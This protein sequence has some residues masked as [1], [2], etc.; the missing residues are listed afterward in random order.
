AHEIKNPLG[1]LRGAA[2]L[3]ESELDSAELQEYTHIIIQEAD[4]LQELV[5]RMLGPNRRPS[6]EPVNIHHVLER[7]RTLVLAETAERMTIIRD[8]DPSIPELIGDHDQLIQAMLNVVRNAA[9]ALGESGTVTLRTRIQRQL[10]IG[11][12]RYRLAAK[13]DIID[14]GPGIPPEIADTLFLPMVTAGTGGMGLGLS[15]AQS[16]INQHRGL[17]ECNSRQG[18]TVFT[19]FLPVGEEPA[20]ERSNKERSPRD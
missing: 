3:L 13:I 18:E 15:I 14:D 20:A 4:R 5:N 16:L 7:V 12:E 11:N 10:T 2:Q 6:F 9:R 8:Y 17:I 19:I 1:G